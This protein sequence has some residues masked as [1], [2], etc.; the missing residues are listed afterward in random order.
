MDSSIHLSRKAA[1]VCSLKYTDNHAQF[2]CLAGAVAD[3]SLTTSVALLVCTRGTTHSIVDCH[4][5]TG[6]QK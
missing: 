6:S 2:T 5:F 3:S 4:E 1:I